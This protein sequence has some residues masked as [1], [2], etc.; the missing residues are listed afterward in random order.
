MKMTLPE[1]ERGE[2]YI[3]SKGYDSYKVQLI[4]DITLKKAHVACKHTNVCLSF[5]KRDRVSQ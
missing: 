2:L 5:H 3:Y 4:K 1:R